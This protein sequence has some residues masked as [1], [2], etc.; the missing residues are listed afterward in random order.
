MNLKLNTYKILI[1]SETVL[2]VSETQNT[3]NLT[4]PSDVGHIV[5]KGLESKWVGAPPNMVSPLM[6]V[7]IKKDITQTKGKPQ[8]PRL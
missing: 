6:V 8:T 5:A 2:P 4:V 1:D 7:E 3:K